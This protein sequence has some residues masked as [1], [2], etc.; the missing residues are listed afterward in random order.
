MVL[1]LLEG[2]YNSY[3][4]YIVIICPTF[5]KNKTYLSSS[6]L[7]LNDDVFIFGE[8]ELSDL[9]VPFR[10]F[11]ENLSGFN[12]L[13]ILDDIISDRVMDKRRCELLRLEC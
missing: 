2:V 4:N 3:F 11:L 9:D 8:G 5:W 7:L 13:F 1:R 10:L 6:S 12:V